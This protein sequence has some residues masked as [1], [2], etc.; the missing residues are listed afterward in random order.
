[1]C[2]GVPM[3]LIEIDYP[4]GIAEAKGVRRNIGLQLLNEED[5]K[6]GDY[7]IVH[8]GFAIERLDREEAENIWR[9]LEE[10]LEVTEEEDA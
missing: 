2:M 1:M 8:V 4:F 3:R 7:V 9:S 10:I 6:V 5:I